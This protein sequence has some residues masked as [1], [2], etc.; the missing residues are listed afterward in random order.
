MKALKASHRQVFRIF[1][2]TRGS[3]FHSVFTF[4]S[5]TG[6]QMKKGNESSRVKGGR[7]SAFFPL[8]SFITFINLLIIG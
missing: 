3:R 6:F 5:V 4:L 1:N 8:L 7:Q 2:P